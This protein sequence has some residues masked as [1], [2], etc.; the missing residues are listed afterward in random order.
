MPVRDSH[1]GC[2]RVAVAITGPHSVRLVWYDEETKERLWTEDIAF[3][4]YVEAVSCI[5]CDGH[6][7]RGGGLVVDADGR[8]HYRLPCDPGQL[9]SAFTDV[10]DLR[11]REA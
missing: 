8:R 7:R 10:K 4:R 9:Q 2:V 3:G 6:F 1:Q 11:H 5:H